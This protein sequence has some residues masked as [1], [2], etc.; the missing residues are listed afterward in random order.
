MSRKSE[1]SDQKQPQETPTNPPV[2][3]PNYAQYDRYRRDEPEHLKPTVKSV[4]KHWFDE[5]PVED[6]RKQLQDSLKERKMYE[7]QTEQINYH[8]SYVKKDYRDSQREYKY[9]QAHKY[10]SYEPIFMNKDAL[11][12][13]DEF[14]PDRFDKLNAKTSQ[15]DFCQSPNRDPLQRSSRFENNPH[16]DSLEKKEFH[17]FG[18]QKPQSKSYNRN[19]GMHK[20]AFVNHQQR[21]E[22]RE[23]EREEKQYGRSASHGFERNFRGINLP[24][25]AQ[26]DPQETEHLNAELNFNK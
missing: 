18:K 2:D 5:Y 21:D 1:E 19:L 9:D 23:A 17:S 15:Q 6:R 24:P 16:N 4:G 26:N 20:R 25:Y 12:S 7:E 22:R 14:N 13:H 11:K 8:Q 3:K 10:S